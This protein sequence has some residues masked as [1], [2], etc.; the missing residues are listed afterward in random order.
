MF[1]QPPLKIAQ[2]TQKMAKYLIAIMP[3]FL[4]SDLSQQ[5]LFYSQIN[6]SPADCGTS[7]E[8]MVHLD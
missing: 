3:T 7:P 8:Y 2:F 6:N 5:I 4:S 1:Y